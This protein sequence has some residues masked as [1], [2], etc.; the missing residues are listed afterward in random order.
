MR[1]DLYFEI[2]EIKITK[3]ADSEPRVCS[4]RRFLPYR[5]ITFCLPCDTMCCQST[6]R[7]VALP[8]TKSLSVN[9]Y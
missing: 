7:S 2:V 4:S 5:N 8:M 9:K 3:N 6:E 1:R